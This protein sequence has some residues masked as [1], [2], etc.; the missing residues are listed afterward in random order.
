M[1]ADSNCLQLPDNCQEADP[2]TGNC[3]TCLPNFDFF[4]GNCY[5]KVVGCRQYAGKGCSG[6][7]QGYSLSANGECKPDRSSCQNFDI[8]ANKCV[9]CAP[10]FALV[11]GLCYKQIANCVDYA[12]NASCSQCTSGYI[13]TAGICI[14]SSCQIVDNG[15]CK[16]CTNGYTLING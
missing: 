2:S 10:G 13:L 16:R 9:V 8:R 15:V 1:D 3:L 14:S 12:N 11:G 7:L 4:R 5:K 6:C